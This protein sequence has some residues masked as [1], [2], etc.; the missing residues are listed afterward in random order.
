MLGSLTFSLPLPFTTTYYSPEKKISAHPVAPALD[1]FPAQLP[2]FGFFGA[3]SF[4]GMIAARNFERLN[5]IEPTRIT[6][7]DAGRIL[8]R[9]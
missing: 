1:L 8:S 4:G 6:L 7:A 2:T 3:I 9:F 5:V